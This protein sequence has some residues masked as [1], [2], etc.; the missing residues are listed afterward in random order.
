MAK[1]R[2]TDNRSDAEFGGTAGGGMACATISDPPTHEDDPLMTQSEVAR[3]LG[4]SPQTIGRW[5]A[6]GLLAFTKLPSGLPVVRRSE[7]NKF[8]G[9]SA[10]PQKEIA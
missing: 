8:L 2:E 3:A 1:K 9:G 7:V 4:K 6:D 10:L 5:I